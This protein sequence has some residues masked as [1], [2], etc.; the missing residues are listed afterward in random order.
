M[1]LLLLLCCAVN[2]CHCFRVVVV[3]HNLNYHEFVVVV[4]VVVSVFGW[5]DFFFAGKGPK[6]EYQK[7]GFSNQRA[8]MI[9]DFKIVRID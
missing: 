7:M 2:Y 6:T 4:V 8:I 9:H 3:G 5:P 1:L